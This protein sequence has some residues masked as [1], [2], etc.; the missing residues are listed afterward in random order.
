MEQAAHWFV[1]LASGEANEADRAGWQAWRAEHPSHELAWQRAERSAARFADIPRAQA[2]VS[3]RALDLAHA[4][5][6]PS[7]RKGLVQ[8]AVLLAAG[9]GGWQLYRASERPAGLITAVGEQREATLADG[10][11]VV[12]D[13]GTALDIEFSSG[14]RLLRLRSGRIMVDTARDPVRPFV[15]ETSDGRVRALGT[16]FTVQQE[17][18]STLVAVLEARVALHGKQAPG[19]API[20]SAG[21]AGRFDSGGLIERRAA[22]ATDAA[23]L[24]GM[25]VADDMR[26]ADLVAQLARYRREQLA[27]DAAAAELRISGTF[28]LRDTGRALAA[29]GSTLPVRLER[30]VQADGNAAILIRRK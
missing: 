7:R 25:L 9:A 11:R 28:P 3:L 20:L 14:Q 4:P 21:Q 8:L 18:N 27:C 13:T 6:S 19:A 23:W 2:A 10:S 12:L 17:P 29:I 5:P 22:P 24:Q 16:R 30:S 1:L 26:L 15:V